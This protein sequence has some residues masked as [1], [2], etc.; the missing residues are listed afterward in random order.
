MLAHTSKKLIALYIFELLEPI[1][2]LIF[3]FHR[4]VYF[5]GISI[6]FPRVWRRNRIRWSQ[7][8][9]QQSPSKVFFPT[10]SFFLDSKHFFLGHRKHPTS[11]TATMLH[12]MRIFPGL[13]GLASRLQL[14]RRDTKKSRTFLSQTRHRSF[15]SIK[16]TNEIFFEWIKKD[17]FN[18]VE[19]KREEKEKRDEVSRSYL[20]FRA[21]CCRCCCFFLRLL[22]LRF[23][24]QIK[25]RTLPLSH[26]LSLPF[27]L[28]SSRL[29]LSHSLA[30]DFLRAVKGV[31]YPFTAETVIT[32]ARRSPSV[33]QEASKNGRG[34]R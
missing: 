3:K 12:W 15:H 6:C 33:F 19:D 16:K 2:F 27:S 23:V 30:N 26:P 11:T 21:G 18:W 10:V 9:K 29:F 25:L 34:R 14:R 13:E 20:G 4:P 17:F 24:C 1:S 28:P 5:V 32:E 8:S 7:H 22:N 31:S